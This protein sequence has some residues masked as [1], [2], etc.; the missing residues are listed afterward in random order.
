M[1]ES[2]LGSHGLLRAKSLSPLAL[3]FTVFCCVSGGPIGLEPLIA[4]TGPLLA[5]LLILVTPLVWAIPDAL[6]S[7]ELAP[8]IPVEGGYVVWVRRAMGPF[9]GFLN[10]WW[11]WLYT[12]VDA[13]LYPVLFTSTIG[14]LLNYYFGSRILLDSNLAHYAVSLSVV[15]L[16]TYL[17]IRGTRIVGM[18]STA[19]ALLIIVPFAAMSIVGLVRMAMESKPLLPPEEIAPGELKQG[20]S[21]GLGIIMWNYLGWDALS[22]VAEEVDQPQKAYPRA[23]LWGVPL[24]A[25]VYFFPTLVGVH[26]YPDRSLWQ[27]GAWPSIARA[28][29]GEWL[30]WGVIV[31]SIVS[32][33]ALFTASLLA[34]SRVPFVLAEERFLPRRLVDVHP[35]FGTPWLAILLCGTLYA[36]LVYQE[37]ASLIQLNVVMYSAALCLETTALLVLRAKEP[38][39]H[40]PFK[41]RGGWPVL[42]L[43][44]ILPILMIGLLAA[45][46]I[47]ED[48]WQSLWLTG[49]ALA[50]AP[51]LYFV[52]WAYE[53]T[54]T[55]SRDE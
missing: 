51:I 34:S 52:K 53:R 55:R 4:E 47:R 38:N 20:L 9:A 23:L 12:I 25:S 41:I 10:A 44:F 29:G 21:A 13:A 19:F 46:S 3:A 36:I 45:L 54:R 7:C 35:K 17:N 48:G 5:L 49:V 2:N 50:S 22:T 33:V 30:A 14:H 28:V 37:F 11:T 16:F 6:T 24:V 31:A 18:A 27:E 8:A 26:Y 32:P 42:T 1:A 15:I 39:L 40:R 43:V